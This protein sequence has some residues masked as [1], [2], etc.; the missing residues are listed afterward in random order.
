MKAGDEVAV[1]YADELGITQRLDGPVRRGYNGGLF[2]G[3]LLVQYST[4]QTPER[5]ILVEPLTCTKIPV[6]DW[7]K[8]DHVVV[9]WSD[10]TRVE[11]K[12]AGVGP[13][14]VEHL[15]LRIRQYDGK[16]ETAGGRTIVVTRPVTPQPTKLGSVVRDAAD[17][18]WVRATWGTRK[19]WLNASTGTWAD[20]TELDN[21]K[22]EK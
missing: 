21:P 2:V 15:G 7:R 3:E 16:V 12:V 22:E 18:L 4:G 20:W 9:T 8:G 19:P 17:D 10:G 14:I 5:I 6:A 13:L 11:G 1:F